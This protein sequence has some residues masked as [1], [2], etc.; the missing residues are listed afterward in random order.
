MGGNYRM[1]SLIFS[2]INEIIENS[3]IKATGHVVTFYLFYTFA[4]PN[5]KGFP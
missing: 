2:G 3:V 1:I 5:P 4:V